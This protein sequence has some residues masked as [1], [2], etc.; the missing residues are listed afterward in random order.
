VTKKQT[1]AAGVILVFKRMMQTIT[2][3]KQRKEIA[4]IA[5]SMQ[6]YYE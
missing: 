3:K 5:I 1:E 6:T 2:E 4:L